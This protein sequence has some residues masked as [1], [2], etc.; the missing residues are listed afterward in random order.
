MSA[1]KELWADCEE[2]GFPEI[3]ISIDESI[4]LRERVALGEFTSFDEAL[5][6]SKEELH[7]TKVGDDWYS[8]QSLNRLKEGIRQAKDGKVV[9]GEDIEA[10]FDEWQAELSKQ[11]ED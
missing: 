5:A 10:W 1:N 7:L 9:P 8:E 6:K 4:A 11:P 3:V 2:D